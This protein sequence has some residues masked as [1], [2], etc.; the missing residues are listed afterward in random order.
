MYIKQNEKQD[1]YYNEWQYKYSGY[2]S[3]HKKNIS[4]PIKW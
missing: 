3:L 4:T 1:L 2:S